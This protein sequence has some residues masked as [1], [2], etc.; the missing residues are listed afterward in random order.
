[1]ILFNSAEINLVH[2][3]CALRR[4]TQ[5]AA[6]AAPSSP[7]FF[8]CDLSHKENKLDKLGWGEPNSNFP[9][10]GNSAAHGTVGFGGEARVPAKRG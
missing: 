1:V 6:A 8:E 9:P 4:R 5:S 7:I 10:T 2:F 3:I